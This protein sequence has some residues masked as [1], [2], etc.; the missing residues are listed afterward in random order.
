MN[1]NYNQLLNNV[2]CEKIRS[3]FLFFDSQLLHRG[4]KIE[5]GKN[6]KG[7]NERGKNKKE[8]NKKE[9]NKREKNKRE[10][11]KREKNKREKKYVSYNTKCGT[12]LVISLPNRTKIYDKKK[13]TSSYNKLLT[14]H[15]H[16]MNK[17][18]YNELNINLYAT[19]ILTNIVELVY[20]FSNNQAVN[21]YNFN[22]LYITHFFYNK[23]YKIK[24]YTGNNDYI[25]VLQKMFP[26]IH[27]SHINNR[28][29]K[30]IKANKYFIST[31]FLQ[32]F[33]ENNKKFEQS[34]HVKKNI[35][36]HKQTLN[37][38]YKI[39]TSLS[40]E[41]YKIKLF[42]N[43][44]KKKSIFLYTDYIYVKNKK[45][46]K[47]I[48][49]L[50]ATQNYYYNTI[51]ELQICFSS[52]YVSKLFDEKCLTKYAVAQVQY[53]KMFFDHVYLIP[54]YLWKSLTTNEKKNHFVTLLNI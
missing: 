35:D 19:I 50:F 53:F 44:L 49:I 41:N 20:N 15:E 13:K 26:L 1:N 48:S 2:L 27:T 33:E 34:V 12:D 31:Y 18:G 24:N 45:T 6:E 39:L 14:N 4:K 10:K 22:N 36:Y 29:L 28:H 38:M 43:K 30:L 51:N 54:Y 5:R 21:I 7:K 25:F 40:Q 37:E 11:N 32:Y 47:K 17:S 3:F 52:K 9:K 46:N 16:Y 8:K 23:I 42:K